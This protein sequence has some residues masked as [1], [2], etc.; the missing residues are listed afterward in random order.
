LY[1][2][3]Y[4]A[5]Q[6]RF[7]A[8]QIERAADAVVW[9]SDTAPGLTPGR[10]Q[11]RA[12]VG[13]I[14]EAMQAYG[15]G[16]LGDGGIKLGDVTRLIAI[17]SDAMMAAIARARAGALRPYL[18]PQHQAIGS[19]NS[20]MQC[21]MKEICGQCLQRHRDPFTNAETVV[22]SC[23]GQ[24]Q[25]L[26]RIDFPSLRARLRQ[27]SVQEKLTRRWIEFASRE[28]SAEIGA[29]GTDL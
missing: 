21:M 8:G 7:K 14:V 12:F 17:G 28:S 3:A 22:F 1:F 25:P 11:D 26:D 19:V 16:T 24:D 18:S 6:D 27:N 10:P 15:Q 4:K 2:A 29:V 9:C 20:P 13:N 5:P 23:A